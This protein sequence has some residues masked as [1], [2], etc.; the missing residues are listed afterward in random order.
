MTEEKKDVSKMYDEVITKH[1]KAQEALTKL[2]T[3]KEL[4][5]TALK[6][7][8]AKYKEE[9]GEDLKVEDLSEKVKALEEEVAASE[10][11]LTKKCE[12]FLEKWDK[13][14]ENAA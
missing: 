14:G 10:A 5:E 9:Y 8:L 11:S 1:G 2:K 3:T 7:A 13:G 12:E 4:K 6:E